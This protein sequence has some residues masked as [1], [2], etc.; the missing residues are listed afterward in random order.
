MNQPILQYHSGTIWAQLDR[1]RKS[2]VEDVSFSLCAGESMALIG[3]TGSGKTMIALSIMKL[4]PSNVK[5]E[6]GS[7]CFCGEELMTKRNIRKLLGMSIVY[8]PQNGLE[9][10]N[11]SKKIR[12]HLYDNLKKMGVSNLD[13]VAREKLRLV[14]FESPEEILDKYPFQLSG[15]MAQRVTIA[16]SACSNARLVIADEPTNGLDEHGKQ[17][18]HKLMNALFPEAAKLV[19]THDIGVAA[20][21]DRTLVLCGGKRMETGLSNALLESPNHPYTKALIGSLVRN[22][23]AETPVLR[24][25]YGICPFY[26]RCQIAQVKCKEAVSCHQQGD[27]EWWCCND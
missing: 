26:R 7:I 9:F 3:E 11:P 18:F 5:M 13:E 17:N 15:G 4:L 23:M 8:I 25:E 16:I 20:L 27:R 22:G 24:S 21:C 14:G 6:K 10:L 2:L 1:S 12:H 19:I